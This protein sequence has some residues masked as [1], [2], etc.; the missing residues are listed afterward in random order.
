MKAILIQDHKAKNP[1]FDRLL[2]LQAKR[3]GYK[4][5]VPRDVVVK[6]GTTIEGPDV[7]RLVRLGAAVPHDQECRD[8]CGLTSEQIASKVASY[9]FIH[10]GI[11]RLHRQA[12][13]EGRMNGYDDNGNPTLDG[14]PVK[15]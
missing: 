3:F 15:I 2:D 13:R 8:R 6:S 4:Y 5:D 10:R 11:S 1:H 14:K 12:F 9:E 7:W